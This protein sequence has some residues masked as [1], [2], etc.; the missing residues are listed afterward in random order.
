MKTVVLYRVAAVVMLVGIGTH[1]LV[2]S[3]KLPEV[4]SYHARIR[5]VADSTP[6]KVG[7][8]MGEDVPV[9]A[10]AISVLSPNVMISRRYLNVETGQNAGFMLVHCSDAHDMAGHF[11]L[12]C[13]PAAGWEVRGA[14]PRDWQ[15]GDLKV[16][17]T[18][19]TFSQSSTVGTGERAESS[20]VV[21]NFILRPDGQV[22][23]DMNEMAKSVIGAGGQA[24]GAGQVQVYFPS[25]VPQA[26]RDAAVVE[27]IRGYRPVLDTIIGPVESKT[28]DH[29]T[30]SSTSLND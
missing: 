2:A 18:E 27:L 9:P 10:Q 20:I 15:V 8:W 29:R 12:R 1:R 7:A 11:P 13:Y 16:T 14:T 19:Y 5:A 25:H 23:R 21:A 17:G 6:R 30:V 22:L 26:R 24:L 28:D 3:R 4:D